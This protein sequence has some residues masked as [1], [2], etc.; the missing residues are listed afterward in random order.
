MISEEKKLISPIQHRRSYY[1]SQLGL[2]SDNVKYKSQ[3]NLNKIEINCSLLDTVSI[4]TPCSTMVK[5]KLFSLLNEGY[6]SVIDQ[7][8]LSPLIDIAMCAIIEW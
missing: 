5:N 1:L 6:Q 4:H 7:Q 3:W 2:F 8:Y